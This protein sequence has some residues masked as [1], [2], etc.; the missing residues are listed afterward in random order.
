MILLLKTFL[1]NLVAL[2]CSLFLF[3]LSSALSSTV[4]N[5]LLPY[6]A[7]DLR[8]AYEI[9]DVIFFNLFKDIK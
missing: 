7:R 8:G 5:F 2:A 1:L 4:N 6:F 9:I 3:R